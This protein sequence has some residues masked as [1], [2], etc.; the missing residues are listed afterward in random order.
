MRHASRTHRVD[1]DG[2]F[3]RNDLDPMIQIKSMREV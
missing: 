1:L 2:S 3:D